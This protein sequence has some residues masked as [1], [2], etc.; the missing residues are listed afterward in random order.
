MQAHLCFGHCTDTR[1]ICRC[2][3]GTWGTC[4]VCC[5][6]SCL[7]CGKSCLVPKNVVIRDQLHLSESS[8]PGC[9]RMYD[10]QMAYTYGPG[11]MYVMPFCV[12]FLS[13]TQKEKKWNVR[14]LNCNLWPFQPQT[15]LDSAFT[16]WQPK[17]QGAHQ[18]EP[19]CA[20]CNHTSLPNMP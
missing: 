14:A 5:R 3:W 16:P 10:T 4:C 15:Q 19:H 2:R 12:T 6:R 7:V 13:V 9:V 20:R 18:L 1:I 11:R 17:V 8:I